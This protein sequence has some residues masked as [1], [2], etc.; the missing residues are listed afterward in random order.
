MGS[1]VPS[2]AY[3]SVLASDWASL[4]RLTFDVLA[5]SLFATKSAKW[6]LFEGES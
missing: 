6:M 2:V 5:G 4:L 1:Q 3:F